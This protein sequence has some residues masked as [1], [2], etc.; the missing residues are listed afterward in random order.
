MMASSRMSGLGYQCQC[1][2]SVEDAFEYGY[3]GFA[4]SYHTSK[5]VSTVLTNNKAWEL[6]L[7]QTREQ[8]REESTVSRHHNHIV[9][10]ILMLKCP[11]CSV[12]WFDFDG[13]AAV[14]WLRLPR[15]TFRT[16]GFVVILMGTEARA[17]NLLIYSSH[18]RSPNFPRCYIFTELPDVDLDLLNRHD[19]IWSRSPW[20]QE[21]IEID[22]R[23][24]GLA[25]ARKGGRQLD[26]S[27]NASPFHSFAALHQ[28]VAM[29][30]WLSIIVIFSK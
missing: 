6:K 3:H 8:E 19:T 27:F 11:R 14:N 29:L 1:R 30:P 20:K 15:K 9:D 10:N 4:R 18:S 23:G 12:A 13:C 26:H 22:Q 7:K 16:A 25:H 5:W 2:M 28:H 24:F 17:A 21:D